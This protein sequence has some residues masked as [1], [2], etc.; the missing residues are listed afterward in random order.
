LS[1]DF[2][3]WQYSDVSDQQTSA[4]TPFFGKLVAFNEWSYVVCTL[5]DRMGL[6][7]WS[8]DFERL[9][10]KVKEVLP[11]LGSRIRAKK[12]P[13]KVLKWMRNLNPQQR[14]AWNELAI[15][16]TKSDG[17]WW[18]EDLAKIV[19]RIAT[20]IYPNHQQALE[21]LQ[22]INAP[23]WLIGDLEKWIVSPQTS[24]LRGKYR[25]A[26]QVLVPESLKKLP[27]ILTGDRR[28]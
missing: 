12:L 18:N 22:G 13:S 19:C 10:Y 6:S 4:S 23:L 11:D 3:K 2:K 16:A 9:G 5:I 8:W 25:L 17:Q 15:F 21:T 14:S 7:A 26:S 28:H 20:V 27:T 24:Q 1:T